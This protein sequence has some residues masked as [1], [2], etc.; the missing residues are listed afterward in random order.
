MRS[1]HLKR[2]SKQLLGVIFLLISIALLSSNAYAASTTDPNHKGWTGKHPK[3]NQVQWKPIKTKCKECVKITEQYNQ[4]VQQ[5][6]DSRYW[7]KFW[8]EVHKNREKGKKDPFWPGKGDINEFEGKAIG[9]NLALFE[10]QAS[11]LELHKKVVRMLEQQAQYLSFAITE[12]ERTACAAEKPSKK[13]KIK[14]GGET[15]KDSFQLDTNSILKQYGIDWQGP[16]RT[17]CLPCKPYTEQLNALPGWVV[18]AHMQLQR[19][20]LMLQYAQLI[21]QSNAIKL[22]FIKYTHPDKTDY[23]TLDAEI[24]K[25]KKELE[26]LKSLFKKLV[27]QLTECQAKYC[28]KLKDDDASIAIGEPINHCPKPPASEVITVGA[29]N[30]VGSKANFREKAKKKAAGLATKAITGLLG[31]G[32]GGGKSEG[33]GTYKDPV[34]KK[35]KFKNKE[36]KRQIR[37][38]GV[39]TEDGLLIS[40]D[41]K[42]APGKGTFQ[43]VYLQTPTGWRLIPIRL[44]MYEIWQDWKLS[45]SWTRDT[46]VDGELVKH[47]E[48]GWTESWSV[49]L[50][51]GQQVDY[52]EIP[53]WEQ[54]GFNTAVS[55]ARSLGTLFPV[56]PAMLA[57]E[58]MNLVIHI[59]D[60]KKDPVITFPYVFQISL[61]QKGKVV[62]E[63]VAQT[64]AATGIPCEETSTTVVTTINGI[65]PTTETPV[66]SESGAGE[67]NTPITSGPSI[68]TTEQPQSCPNGWVC[69][70]GKICPPIQN[71][72]VA[73]N[74]LPDGATPPNEPSI[75]EGIEEIEITGSRLSSGLTEKPI[76]T[77]NDASLDELEEVDVTGSRVGLTPSQPKPSTTSKPEITN[78]S[79]SEIEYS[80]TA[81]Y[82]YYSGTGVGLS[83]ELETGNTESDETVEIPTLEI[84]DEVE[85][86]PVVGI[87]LR[88]DNPKWIPEYGNNTFVLSKMYV[89]H[90]TRPGIWVPHPSVK[91]NMTI[92]FISRSNEKG[93][94]MNAS[95]DD[96]QDTFPDLHFD[97][98][99]NFGSTCSNDPT[100]NGYFGTCKTNTPHNEKLFVINSSDYGGFSRLDVSCEG[101]VPL[102][103]IR[104]QMPEGT[105]EFDQWPLAVEEQNQENRAVYVP[106][107]DNRNQISDGYVPDLVHSPKA[108]DDKEVIPFGNGVAGDG[109]S[110][111]E[112]Y[113]GFI[114][115]EN[116]HQRT[117]WHKKTL[118]IENINKIS[119]EQFETA[120][121]LDVIDIEAW[122]HRDR[123]INFNSGHANLVDQHGVKLRLKP[124]LDDDFAGYC[125]CEPIQRPKTADLVAI[126]PGSENSSTVAHELGHSVGMRHHGD[127]P[128]PK[129]KQEIRPMTNSIN[130]LLPG[131]VHSNTTLCGQALPASFFIG[132]KGDQGSGNDSCIMRYRHTDYVYEQNESGEDYDCMHSKPRTI[133]DDSPSGTG[134]NSH[135]RTADDATRGNCMSQ[136]WINSQ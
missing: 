8:K 38:G 10:N 79:T 63:E 50:A 57:Y 84:T 16:Y 52:A 48:G 51:K 82:N 3:M 125:Y 36:A 20:E 78:D 13:K 115:A 89:P 75:D 66:G 107:D 105:G 28:A 11:Q 46:F 17:N 136:M 15:T 35:T 122:H 5:L 59:T 121:G 22:D 2:L 65:E 123:V 85:E 128:W 4:T 111:Y 77:L 95:I 90:P 97:A 29:N 7:V 40:S 98:G 110:A 93:K 112:E 116:K 14:I 91:R 117:D 96:F 30:D 92:V 9:A 132:T 37:V 68:N 99:R 102:K 94:A 67:P 1:T 83:Y 129:T 109:L 33:P 130:D 135:H 32:G 12:C 39:F 88:A 114:D 53:I 42:K 19:T 133:F 74:N 103:A 76:S 104:G 80:A 72:T 54:L 134:I 64:E 31:I 118:L 70:P 56:N 71:C 49:L 41:I 126:Q 81:E 108:T 58:P 86:P 47:E 45:V 27:A 34:K 120:S 106:R 69:M 26:A 131:R 87:L 6:L 23:G 21:K 55:G 127:I 25:L 24:E 101:C 62:I 73:I 113:R 61:N 18:R 119:T 100:G 43:T 124:D 44:F 60:P